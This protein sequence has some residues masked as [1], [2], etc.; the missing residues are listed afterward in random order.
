MFLIF[1][2]FN[3]H[4]GLLDHFQQ[5]YYEDTF[6]IE[7]L[8]YIR[9]LRIFLI[10]KILRLFSYLSYM[11]F[12]K[13]GI[14]NTISRFIYNAFLLM[15]MLIIY[16]GYGF[17][18]FSSNI[19]AFNT[20]SYSMMSVLQIITLDNWYVLFAE[21]YGKN[22][23]ISTFI[24]FLTLIVLGNYI[25]LNL[26]IALV[27]DG[28]ENLS[29]EKSKKKKD[30]FVEKNQE[31][32]EDFENDDQK[33]CVIDNYEYLKH[34]NFND[35]LKKFQN[36]IDFKAKVS[37]KTIPFIEY[38]QNGSKPKRYSQRSKT[39]LTD[40]DINL[41]LLKKVQKKLNF[42]ET[43]YKNLSEK[44]SL[45]IFSKKNTFRKSCF[46]LSQSPCFMT[47]LNFIIILLSLKF[48]FDTWIDWE[49]NDEKY[50]LMKQVSQFC[51]FIFFAIFSFEAILKSVSCGLIFCKDSYLRNFFNVLNFLNIIGTIL[52]NFIT[53]Q[54][55]LIFKVIF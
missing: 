5:E 44:Y 53:N 41:H 9:F 54:S 19:K 16:A 43:Q 11:K 52:S 35:F 10:L 38:T 55:L 39:I 12:I 51:D 25:F 42:L 6:I 24:F 26:F 34:M 20:F 29:K 33:N 47:F 13:A 18:I 45:F 1:D 23:K 30:L 49:S 28:F 21:C 31:D 46:F 27:L 40:K 36:D 7:T 8:K 32:E 48:G 3:N 2:F 37:K 4:Y 22:D 15:L 50:R 14:K 17:Q